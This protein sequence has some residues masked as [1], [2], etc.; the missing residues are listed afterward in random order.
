MKN[1]SIAT[2]ISILIVVGVWALVLSSNGSAANRTSE[3]K[4]QIA[5]NVEVKTYKNTIPLYQE[6][7]SLEPDEMQWYVGLAD[8]YRETNQ[9]GN[10]RNSVNKIISTFPGEKIGYLRKIQLLQEIGKDQDVLTFF[11]NELP[12]QFRSD[13][14]FLGV[15]K[16]CEWSYQFMSS[17]YDEAGPIIGE[18]CVVKKNGLYGYRCVGDSEDLDCKFD[19]ARPFIEQFAAVNKGQE[20]YFIDQEGDR[21]IAFKEPVDDLYSFS[22]GYAA[23]CINGKYG[24]VDEALRQYNFEYEFVTTVFNGVAA[25][26]K[27]D[28]WALLD[29]SFQ[30]ITE[31]VYEDVIRDEANICSRKGY[32]FAKKDGG[33]HL[34][35]LSGTEVG[36]EVYEDARL[37]YSDYA[38]VKLGGKWGFIDQNGDRKTEFVYDNASSYA[39]GIAAVCQNDRWGC[40]DM[41]GNEI[42]Q[43]DYNSA[44]VTTENGIV[45]LQVGNTYRLVKFY[46]FG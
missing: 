37:F 34:L 16:N 35:D 32:I 41:D 10:Y 25:A 13:E 46:K 14:D 5:E 39:S 4:K 11:N 21:V 23:A 9:Y 27:G 45:V 38:A 36:K 24:Y 40:I 15:Y 22:E 19:V 17:M 6:L 30:P 33:Y 28:R 12:E 42:L 26:K 2:I 44:S 1:K 7:I 29:A 20:W 8:A 43:F 3:L 18:Y 31:F